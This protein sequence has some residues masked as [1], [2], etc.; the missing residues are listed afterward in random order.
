MHRVALGFIVAL[1]AVAG[2]EKEVEQTAVNVA[3]SWQAP[4]SDTVATITLGGEGNYLIE[5]E[6]GK[7]AGTQLFQVGPWGKL[8]PY[9]QWRLGDGEI[10]FSEDGATVGGLEIAALYEDR[11]LFKAADGSP[12]YFNRVATRI[13]PTP[14]DEGDGS[15]EDAALQG[16]AMDE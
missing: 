16:D 4:F 11:I 8:P 9:G 15:G 2:C 12:M 13:V 10:T 14:P 7:T 1:F 3:G 5:Q 6:D